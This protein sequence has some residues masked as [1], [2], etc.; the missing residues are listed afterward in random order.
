M[1]KFALIALLF[2]APAVPGGLGP[3]KPTQVKPAALPRLELGTK[4]PVQLSSAPVPPG[5]SPQPLKVKL[6]QQDPKAIETIF[7]D[8]ADTKGSRLD[9]SAMA[10]LRAGFRDDKH[11]FFSDRGMLYLHVEHE[12]LGDDDVEIA[13]KGDFGGGPMRVG[14]MSFNPTLG[15]LSHGAVSFTASKSFRVLV[16]TSK[17]AAVN[18]GYRV[19]VN[20]GTGG[21]DHFEI[22]RCTA[23]R[24]QPS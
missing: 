15:Y 6:P 20:R 24:R 13:C 22:R 4:A 1:S 19:V 12:W 9:A 16:E 7:F 17:I 18:G 23:T 2:A 5:V 8:L 11:L 10:L 21:A 14:V 3:A